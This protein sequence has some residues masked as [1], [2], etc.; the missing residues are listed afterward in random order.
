MKI[1]RTALLVLAASCATAVCAVA[2][3]LATA[4]PPSSQPMVSGTVQSASDHS[5]T[6]HT[7]EGE[8]MTFIVDSHSVVPEH[9]NAGMR[10]SVE[11]K[12]MP[13]GEFLAQ[14]V[15]PLRA[16]EN[17]NTQTTVNTGELERDR[18]AMRNGTGEVMG[19]RSNGKTDARY[20]SNERNDGD[21]DNDNDADDLPQT[22]S[23]EPLVLLL[24]VSSLAAGAALW[25][26]RRRHA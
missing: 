16:E 2:H 21:E 7:D 4:Y 15:V 1:W 9:M 26:A 11:F 17:R 22:A 13:S 10:E 23:T 20:A 24:G 6:L 14:R 18:Y 5:L 8:S 12:A 25:V 19:Y 3:P